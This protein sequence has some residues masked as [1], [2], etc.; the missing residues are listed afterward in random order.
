MVAGPVR[1]SGSQLSWRGLIEVMDNVCLKIRPVCI[2]RLRAGRGDVPNRSDGSR[3]SLIID[4]KT[5]LGAGSLD[6]GV[7]R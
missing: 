4:V 6:Y 1:C 3:L 2:R 7:L 5:P